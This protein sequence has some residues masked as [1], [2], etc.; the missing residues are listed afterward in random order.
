[1][2]GP[3]SCGSAKPPT[4]TEQTL[5]AVQIAPDLLRGEGLKIAS[6]RILTDAL[7]WGGTLVDFV[8]SA[9]PELV[10]EVRGFSPGLLRVFVTEGYRLYEMNQRFQTDKR[11][12]SVVAKVD[13]AAATSSR[14]LAQSYRRQIYRSD[15]RC[16]AARRRHPTPTGRS[17]RR[18]RS[19]QRAPPAG[20]AHARAGRRPSRAP[21]PSA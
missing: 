21:P 17:V 9:P 16:R 6:D 3:S 10:R 14:K 13:M 19:G 20:C 4:A 5:Y 12:R 1:M 2:T 11:A 8:A 7:R 15:Q 18:A